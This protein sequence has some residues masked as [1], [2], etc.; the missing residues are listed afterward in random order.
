[1]AKIISDTSDSSS[2][3]SKS[4]YRPEID[5]LRALAVV[6]VIINHFNKGVLPSGYLGVDIFFVISGFVITSSLAGRPNKNFADLITGFYSRRIKRLVPALAWFITIASLLICL[7]QQNPVTSLRTAVSALFGFSNLYLLKQATDYFGSSSDLNVFTH[8]WSL[9]V[10]EQFYFLFPILVWFTGFGRLTTKGF[11]NLFWVAGILSVASLLGFIY[12]YQTNQ[13]DAYFFMPTRFW[14][15][16]AGCLLFLGLKHP[17]GYLRGIESIP[18]LAVIA[19]IVGVLFMPFQLAVLTTLAVVAL[20]LVLIACLR[21]GTACYKLLTHPGVVYIG[22]ISYSLYLWHWGVLALSRWTIG[23]HWWSIPFQVILMLLLSIGSY[24]YIETPLRRADWHPLRWKSIGYGIGVLLTAASLV[25]FLLFFG[26]KSLYTGE[27]VASEEASLSAT[28][29]DKASGTILLVGDSHADHFSRMIAAIA[30]VNRMHHKVISVE[31]TPFPT[32]NISTPVNGLTFSKNQQNNQKMMSALTTELETMSPEG[33][34]LI[35]LS[36]F[37]RIYFEPPTGSRK[38]MVFNHY[39][40]NGEKTTPNKSLE[41]WLQKL[42]DFA[43]SHSK[44]KIVIILSTPEM[45]EIYPTELC[46]KEWFRPSISEKCQVSIPRNRV[47]DNLKNLNTKITST[48]SD[49]KNVFVFDPTPS[50]CPAG[51]SYCFSH[52]SGKR[53]YSDEDHLT[54][55]GTNLV[56]VAFAKFLDTHNIIGKSSSSMSGAPAEMSATLIKQKVEQ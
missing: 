41:D 31:A 38:F 37:Y 22:M 8:T 18:S 47:I 51:E 5:G 43:R 19:G 14:E 12:L 4:P 45:P 49:I 46:K 48:V 27:R 56:K 25:T 34:N 30:S 6:A 55:V 11:R 20:T 32:I 50:L 17:N 7:F 54:Q 13:P 35:I 29:G 28:G 1:M 39:S 24:R 3:H 44:T 42:A 40:E 33:G 26:G 53:L 2:V 21:S 10:E 23:I 16:G 9:G 15:L 36:A 52:S